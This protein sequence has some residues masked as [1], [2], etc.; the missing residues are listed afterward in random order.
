M[1]EVED[2]AGGDYDVAIVGG[3]PAGATVG[4][5]LRKY[6]PT[7]SVVILER[8]QFPREHVG[9]S[10]LPLIS[11][12]LDEMGAWEK[13][14]AAGFPIKVGG[15]YRWGKTDDLWDLDFLPNGKFDP[16]PR[17]GTY[18]GQRTC[19]AFQ[20]DRAIYDEI[21]LRHAQ[22]CGC[23]VFQST[24]V[25]GLDRTGDRIDAL[26]TADGSR[27]TARHYVDAS[28]QAG[29]LRKAMDVSVDYPTNLQNIAIWNYW[30]NTEWAVSLGIDGTRI[31]V[32]A[33]EVGWIWFI[34]L[35]QDRTSIGLVIPA[36]HYKSL[37]RSPDE[38]YYEAVR[39]DKIISRLVR[40]ATPEDRVRATKDWSSVSERLTGDNWFLAGESAGFA[41]P[42]LSAGMSLTHSGARDVAYT[43][44]ALDR[45][46]Y[47]TD[48]LKCQYCVSHR[49]HIRQHI[50]FA[51]YWYTARGA[52]PDLKEYVKGMAADAGYA[53]SA[54]EAWRWIGQG[55]FI[56]PNGST[57]IGFFGSLTTKGLIST[58]TGEGL[59]Y[60][61]EGKTH[62]R[63][64]LAGA[65]KDWVAEME[66]GK[67]TRARAYRRD[68]KVLPLVRVMG[69]TARYLLEEHS[70]VELRDA[71]KAESAAR[72]LAKNQYHYF[73]SQVVK[74]LETL[75]TAGWATARTEPGHVPCPSFPADITAA[76]HPNRD[77]AGLI[78]E[79]ADA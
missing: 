75:V 74:C 58:F 36:E 29:V 21:L 8:E 46:E 65:Q 20:V 54:E 38:I 24:A 78:K 49:A 59:F 66:A 13:V 47:E 14:E 43:I 19:T 68:G 52:F 45:G 32:L 23:T 56:D 25:K 17:P 53:L 50:R 3:G 70:Y 71:V 10:Q 61:I 62:F 18:A 35:G 41:D 60:E 76:L 28:G 77:V 2:A 33:L 27:I 40:L 64:D 72:S 6:N 55:G 67:I 57:D 48:W 26:V 30:T 69:W 42:I 12:I 7:L 51:D 15:T 1:S 34:P 73:W 11:R 16:V 63:L 5:L 37:K 4:S 44:L 31:V 39:S 22:S 79:H 9:E